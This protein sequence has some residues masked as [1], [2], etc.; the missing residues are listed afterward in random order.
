MSVLFNYF[1]LEQ[2]ILNSFSSRDFSTVNSQFV[3]ML[4]L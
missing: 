1:V 2:Y 4:S 3:E